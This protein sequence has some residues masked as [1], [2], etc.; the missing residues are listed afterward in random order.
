MTTKKI[1][2]REAVSE[3][4][5]ILEQVENNELDVDELAGKVQR[6]S[7]LL[8]MCREK[9][10]QTSEQVEQILKEMEE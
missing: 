6:V 5:A 8:K 1:S 9:L 10:H 2:Y 4:E 3:I 7:A